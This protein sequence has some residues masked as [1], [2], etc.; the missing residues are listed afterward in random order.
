MLQSATVHLQEGQIEGKE[1][2]SATPGASLKPAVSV[3]GQGHLHLVWIDTAGFNH[4]RVIYASTAPQVGKVLNRITA[5]EVID[6]VFSVGMG[7]ISLVALVPFVLL[8]ALPSFVVL[9]IYSMA[10]NESSLDERRSVVVLAVAILLQMVMQVWTMAGATEGWLGSLM[11][12]GLRDVGWLIPLLISGLAV[13]AMLLYLR[14]TE[15]RTIFAGFLV[16]A[17]VNILLFILI[18]LVPIVLGRLGV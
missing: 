3:D 16:Y 10:T 7:A 9:V 1:V 8:W 11:P 5:G 17:G 15:N 14:R 13:G 12:A 6:S 4:Y 18:Y 2:V